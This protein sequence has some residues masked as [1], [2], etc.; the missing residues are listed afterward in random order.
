MKRLTPIRIKSALS[1]AVTQ[2][3]FC[4]QCARHPVTSFEAVK[5]EDKGSVAV[6]IVIVALLFITMVLTA[7]LT[8]FIFNT[9]NP[10]NFSVIN[11][12]AVS[13]GGFGVVFAAHY[14]VS[15]FLPSEA[16]LRQLFITLAYPLLP[17]I[18]IQL[19]LIVLSNLVAME[20]GIFLEVLN[21]VGIGWAALMLV[22]GMVQTH[23][24]SFSLVLA[25]LALTAVG[26]GIILF[27]MLLLYSLF[28]QIYIFL[29]TILNEVMFRF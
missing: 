10:D 25:D 2:A 17:Y 4:W 22:L 8:G 16:N 13:V 9:R 26:S 11:V 6:G 3:R 24:I 20:M 7:Q 14:A 21:A 12:F 28:Q 23:R 19:I 15:T 29:Y 18:A 27:F 5:W 1:E